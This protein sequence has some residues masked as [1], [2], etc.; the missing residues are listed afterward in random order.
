MRRPLTLSHVWIGMCATIGLLTWAVVRLHLSN[1]KL[2]IGLAILLAGSMIAVTGC[3][4]GGG[5]NSQP[6]PPQTH[7]VVSSGTV[8][9]TVQ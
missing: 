5:G 8:T 9:L 2:W 1:P 7:Q 4:G 6:P 3:G